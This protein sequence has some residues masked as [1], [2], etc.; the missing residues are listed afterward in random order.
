MKFTFS[1]FS[2]FIRK[3]REVD[4]MISRVP[5]S[6]VLLTH[7]TPSLSVKLVHIHWWPGLRLGSACS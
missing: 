1:G 7:S 6:S 5:P 4:E 2:I 3:M